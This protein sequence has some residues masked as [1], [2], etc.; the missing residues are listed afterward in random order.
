M[1]TMLF[2]NPNA[3]YYEYL[4][5]QT[6]WLD[7]Y[8]SLGMNILIWNYRGY[9]RSHSSCLSPLALMKDGEKVFHYAKSNL[10]SGK[11]GVHGQSMGGCV[12]AYIAKKCKVDFV[13][14]DRTFASVH[15]VA[16]WTFGGRVVGCFFQIFTLGLWKSVNCFNEI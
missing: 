13:F 10:V 14:I 6:E 11:I 9:V 2:C 7:Y 15:D 4:P 16:Y 8:Y 1:P 5:Y 3:C 12:A